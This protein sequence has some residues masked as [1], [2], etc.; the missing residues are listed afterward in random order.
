MTTLFPENLPPLAPRPRRGLIRL[1][2][3]QFDL[4]TWVLNC[5]SDEARARLI[6]MNAKTLYRARR[7]AIG[8]DFIAQILIS[9]GDHH[10]ELAKFNLAPK[11]DELFEVVRTDQNSHT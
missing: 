4:M 5:A 2:D 11:F 7:G 10:E 1:R 8:E 6:D 3:R 9:L